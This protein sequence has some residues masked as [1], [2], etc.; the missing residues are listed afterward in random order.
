[1]ITPVFKHMESYIGQAKLIGIDETY[2]ECREKQRI[3]APPEDE[4]GKKAQ[5]SKAKTIRSYVFG[6]ITPKVCIYLHSQERNSDI[7]KPLLLEQTL[8]SKIFE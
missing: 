2:W 7:P 4:L 8:V 5:R 6:V 1:M 3:K